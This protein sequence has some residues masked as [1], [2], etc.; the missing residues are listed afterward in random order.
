YLYNGAAYLESTFAAFKQRLVPVNVN[1]RYTDAELVYLLDNSDAEVLVVDTAFVANVARILAELPNVKLIIEVDELGEGPNPAGATIAG[2]VHYGAAIAAAAPAP[3]IER[4]LEDL[5]FLYTGGTTGM[6]K[7]VMWPHRSLIGSGGPTF[8]PFGFA[9]PQS[10]DEF[11][12]L[13]L[14]V[15]DGAHDP[16]RLLPA[17]PLMHGTSAIASWGVLNSA[18]SVVLLTSRSFDAAELLSTVQRRAVTNLTIVGDAFA[19]PMIAE[20]EAAEERGEP[21][22][23][24]SLRLVVS[25]GVMWSQQTKEALLARADVACADLLG[26]S[27]GVGFANSVAKRNRLAPTA[28]FRLG[29][30]AQVFNDAGERVVPGSGERGVLAVGGPIPIGYYKDSAKSAETFRTFEGRVWS[31]PGDFATVEADGT[32]TLLGRGSVC[33]NTAGE[34]VFAEEVEETLKRHPDV[35]DANVVGVPDEKWGNAVVAVI[36]LEPGVGATEGTEAELRTHCRATLAGYKIPKRIIFV[37]SVL[38]GPNGKADYRWAAAVASDD[39]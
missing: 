12:A 32:I 8:K 35:H 20:L 31:V 15:H 29:P 26:S 11:A 9:V 13:A 1:Y 17:A 23:L 33:I 21:Y 5:W 4:S 2:L 3:H 18:G 16:I 30:D 38:R 34:K 6:P 39:R 19:K 36:G 24:S 37:D 22:D 25:S 14:T 27:E 7:G 10:I 28:R